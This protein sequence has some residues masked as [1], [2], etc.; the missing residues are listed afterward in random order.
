[1]NPRRL[2][3]SMSLLLAFDASARH[4]SFTRAA[5]ELATTQSAVSKQVQALEELVGVELFIRSGR[6]ITLTDVGSMYQRELAGHLA[7]IRNATLQAIAYRNGGG[8]LHLAVLPT[9]TTKWLMPRLHE[10]YASHAQ[11]EL[12]VHSRIGQIDTDKSGMDA[13]IAV[14]DGTWAGCDSHLLQ[15]EEL[16]PIISPQLAKSHPVHQ[17]ADLANHFLLRITARPDAWQRWLG[18]QGVNTG[19]LRYGP[20]FELTSHLIQAVTAGIGV[21]LVPRYFIQDE[22]EAGTVAIA[23]PSSVPSNLGYYLVYLRDRATYPALVQ[24][25][26]WL[27]ASARRPLA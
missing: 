22:L 4:L 8:S 6:K 26:D 15:N 24:F 13:F 7:G 9:F 1:M 18:A 19:R 17:V 5:D 11:V 2:T 23:V 10:F 27:L 14:G 21:G 12:H 3:P 16:V 20:I 25:R